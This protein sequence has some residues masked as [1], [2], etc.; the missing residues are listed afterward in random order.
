MR[1]ERGGARGGRV[2]VCM[3]WVWGVY[4]SGVWVEVGDVR[5]NVYRERSFALP[6]SLTFHGLSISPYTF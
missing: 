4:V 5:A 2:G 6:A 3:T 1:V